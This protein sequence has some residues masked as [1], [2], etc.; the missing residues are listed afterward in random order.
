MEVEFPLQV[1]QLR[2]FKFNPIARLKELVRIYNVLTKSDILLTIVF[3]LAVEKRVSTQ[4]GEKGRKLH[5][6]PL[7]PII[8]PS[9][10]SLSFND[11][12]KHIVLFTKSHAILDDN[13][14]P[15]LEYPPSELEDGEVDEYLHQVNN[16]PDAVWVYNT[17]SGDMCML[18]SA[19]MITYADSGASNHCFVNRGNFTTYQSLDNMTGQT[20]EIGSRF[21]ILGKGTV[22]K[23]IN[24]VKPLFWILPM[25]YIHPTSPLTLS[26]LVICPR[27]AAQSLSMVALQH[28]PNLQETTL[29]VLEFSRACTHLILLIPLHKH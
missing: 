16:V 29:S 8:L 11:N 10:I 21:H 1:Q 15:V 17:D 20:A 25:Y 22:Q 28:L 9:G 23:F 2:H 19:T 5:L 27:W 18:T 13:E 3:P 6:S 7:P 12:Y 14:L 24:N 4:T 26:P